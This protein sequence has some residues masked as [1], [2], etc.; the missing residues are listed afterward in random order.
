[1]TLSLEIHL[2]SAA[3]AVL[4]GGGA[5]VR[6]PRRPANRWFGALAGSIA[7]WNLA[8]A[9]GLAGVAPGFVWPKVYLF[10]GLLAAP[11]GLQLALALAGA[12]RRRRRMAW[13]T[14]GT[15]AVLFWTTVFTPLYEWD[16]GWNYLAMLLVGGVLAWGLVILYRDLSRRRTD[17]ERSVFGLV[18]A[19]AVVAVAGG[20]SDFLPRGPLGFPKLGQV[21]V[22]VFLLTVAALLAR[23]RFLDVD[24]FFLRAA[25]LTGASAAA[26][27]AAFL[28]VRFYGV[29]WLPLFLVA[30]GLVLFGAL[31]ARPLLRESGSW[32]AG[33]DLLAES[34]IGAGREIAAARR[35]EE[36]W[37]AIESRRGILPGGTRLQVY[38]RA[39]DAGFRPLWGEGPVQDG[40]AGLPAWL[41]EEGEPLTRRA[42]REATRAEEGETGPA[43]AAA[44]LAG[45]E[46]L[47]DEMVVP[48]FHDGKLAGWLG[49]G[50]GDRET[51]LTRQVAAALQAVGHQAL[52]D[53][54]R[55]E[56]TERAARQET[57]AAVGQMAA[58]LAHEIRNPVAA[59]RGAADVLCTAGGP[60]QAGE[61][62]PVIDQET[63]RLE[64][65]VEEFLDYARLPAPKRREVDLAALVKAVLREAELA[66]LGMIYKL[67]TAPGL[68]PAALDPAQ[69]QRALANLVRNARE[70][71]GPGGVLEITLTPLPGGGVRVRL[72]DDGP[73][74]PPRLLGDIFR[75]F[76]TG[77]A[78]GTGLG[79][80]LVHRVV[81]AHRGTIEAEAGRTRGAAFTITFPG[82]AVQ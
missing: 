62:L 54:E 2:A 80:A 61:M 14:T 43:A 78:Q 81:E 69:I 53:L 8:T 15:A 66:G 67:N 73:G 32:L 44:A 11:C 75:P 37:Q 34:I 28:V 5:L 70:A 40:R 76:V 57:L 9:S 36:V 29:R 25:G 68:G 71:A 26:A 33:R 13:W 50:G 20:V 45:M 16:P 35:R 7:L 46:T 27:S 12:P 63:A 3:A 41:A 18:F 74:I 10:G 72:E 42:L 4:L 58:G 6:G 21:A 77:R 56:A 79:L 52:A 47:G 51:Y 23:H 38:A 19:A 65:V 82:A 39:S 64:Q 30:L 59:L 60:D 49:L 31:L 48:L 17:P 55:I 22:F 1:M 24:V